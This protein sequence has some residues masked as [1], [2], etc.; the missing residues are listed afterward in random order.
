LKKVIEHQ[1]EIYLFWNKST[2]IETSSSIIS[3]NNQNYQSKGTCR[4]EKQKGI[5]QKMNV[6]REFGSLASSQCCKYK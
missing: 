6:L 3:S 1:F 2:A 4:R 5:S